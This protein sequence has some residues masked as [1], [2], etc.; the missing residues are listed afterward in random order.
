M[1]FRT[2]LTS[3]FVLIVVVPMAAV[4]LLVF[5][6]ISDSEQGKADARASGLA[7]AAQSIYSA[8]S[9]SA[10]ADA[11]TLARDAALLGASSLSARLSSLANQAGLARVVIR[12]G[13][14]V[15]ADVGN[16]TAIAPGAA[17]V[18]A[19]PGGRPIRVT[20]STLLASDLVHELATPPT[21]QVAVR[22][23]G[24]TLAA[25]TRLAASLGAGRQ[26]VTLAGTHYRAVTQV[27]PGFGLSPVAVSALSD[28]ST[29][30]SSVGASR[31]LAAIFIAGFLVLAFAF[32]LLASRALQGQL[33]RFL[34]AA[35]RLAGGDFSSPIETRG[36][37]EFAGLGEEFNH[38]SRQLEHRLQELSEE[39]ARLRE[40]IR[41]IGLT[42]ASNLDR[43]AL[44]E[45]ALRTAADAVQAPSGR[46]SARWRSHESLTETARVGSLTGFEQQIHEAE[47]T[48]LQRRGLG[49]SSS[50]EVSVASVA[51]GPSETGRRAGAVITVCR[52]GQPFSD[53]DRD[54]LRSLGTQATMALEN[55]ELHYQV[56]RQAVTDELTGLANHRRFQE[57]LAIEVEQVRR[58]HHHVGLIMID[59]DDF[60]SVNDT[61]GHPQ[62][63]IVLKEVSNVLRETSRD[64][65]APA[66]YGGE[67]MA[68]ILPHTDLE[69][70]FAIAERV[71]RAIEAL[72]VP[73]L[74]GEGALHIT[75]SLGVT[76]SSGA[77]KDALIADADAALYEAKRQGKN[78]TVRA[79]VRTANV[80]GGQ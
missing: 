17:T 51:L 20:V 69:G 18:R 52:R 29:T 7:T 34:E 8:A 73:R 68:L 65:D 54:V 25:S 37:D 24:R 35:R 43:P 32:S 11:Q 78:R 39:R 50:E 12:L 13:P 62:G 58:Y 49:E 42:F 76:A 33:G 9:A 16:R 46:V 2:R 53:D 5:R 15:V 70:S 40:S 3:F 80:S 71:R 67:E 6:L 10:R 77:E 44:L 41:R 57:L 63:D 56:R 79:R 19:G 59:V 1:S 28:Q 38:M 4:G 74:D 55:V 30:A 60:K 14:R 75:V 27:L 31:L 66:R 23:A 64:A 72:E 45:L 21:V 61:Y 47:R 36:H 26:T 48:A 22:A